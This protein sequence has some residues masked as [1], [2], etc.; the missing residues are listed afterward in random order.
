MKRSFQDGPVDEGPFR[1]EGGA[2]G[3]GQ[4]TRLEI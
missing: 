3:E 2:W 4:V 1:A